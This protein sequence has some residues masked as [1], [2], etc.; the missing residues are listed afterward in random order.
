[1]LIRNWFKIVTLTSLLMLTGCA[2]L[3]QLPSIGTPDKVGTSAADAQGRVVSDSVDAIRHKA[4]ITIVK[5]I[6]A[7]GP[8]R[9]L[10]ETE[11]E[12]MVADFKQSLDA[13]LQKVSRSGSP[14]EVAAATA[15]LQRLDARFTPYAEPA[16]EAAILKL[17][18]SYGP[19][20]AAT[21]KSDTCATRMKKVAD[22]AKSQKA[23]S[24]ASATSTSVKPG[25]TDPAG[26]E[27]LIPEFEKRI[28]TL[29]LYKNLI[30]S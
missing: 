15:K 29:E 3:G 25:P 1:M 8:E 30:G 10:T 28:A 2:Q 13:E 18:E 4:D 7:L 17:V 19:Q 9:C 12:L 20:A 11:T 27:V 21:R 5:R 16:S 23:K 22:F 24:A 14:T 26:I 6:R